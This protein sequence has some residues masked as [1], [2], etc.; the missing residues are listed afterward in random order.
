MNRRIIQRFEA[1]KIGLPSA[2]PIVNVVLPSAT[3]P[4]HD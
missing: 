2:T 1:A 4:P 3:V